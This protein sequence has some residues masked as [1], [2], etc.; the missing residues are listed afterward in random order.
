MSGGN[1]RRSAPQVSRLRS[2][3]GAL[4]C[5]AWPPCSVRFLF[6]GFARPVPACPVGQ[7]LR[8]APGGGESHAPRPGRAHRQVSRHAR[9]VYL[10]RS[11]LRN[12]LS[13]GRLL[14]L[15]SVVARCG[16]A[17]PGM[18]GRLLRLRS[19]V[20]P[21]GYPL[22]RVAGDSPPRPSRGAKAQ[23][24]APAHIRNFVRIEA[25]SP[26]SALRMRAPAPAPVL[27]LVTPPGA[28]LCRGIN[29][30]THKAGGHRTRSKQN[31]HFV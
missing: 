14:R 4:A 20:A 16:A 9:G 2:L 21:E 7:G 15:R 19:V 3:F 28:F 6:S 11:L 12:H 31:T 25:Y 23:N 29:Q 8:A 18:P 24:G 17:A 27:L 26:A 22:R 30:L 13:P 10:K 5:V 1:P